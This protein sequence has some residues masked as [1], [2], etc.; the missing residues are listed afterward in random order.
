LEIIDLIIPTTTASASCSSRNGSKRVLADAGKLAAAADGGT[1]LLL[2]VLL[3]LCKLLVLMSLRC[4][5][6]TA[7]S[8]SAEFSCKASASLG[9]S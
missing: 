5:P 4:T 7:A 1:E 9:S 8:T 6:L 3:V 2:A